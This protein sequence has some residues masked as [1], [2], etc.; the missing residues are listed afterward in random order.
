MKA[1]TIFVSI[2][3]ASFSFINSAAF[4]QNDSKADSIKK[5]N[6]SM[7]TTIGIFDPNETKSG[8]RINDYYVELSNSRM[9]TLKG[10]KVSVT[11]DLVVIRGMEN[12]FTMEQ[13]S[14]SDRKIITKPVITFINETI[15]TTV[16]VIDSNETKSGYRINEYYIELN[17]AQ[18]DSYKGK[19]VSVTGILLIVPGLDK[20]EQIKSQGSLSDRKFITK[21]V[22]TIIK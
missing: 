12:A 17:R 5:V 2:I 13:G 4:A 16:G 19:K 8:F 14:Y 1:S 9:D 18:I 21:P 6:E 22:I 20:D 11:G 7:V 3:L 15:I 10:K